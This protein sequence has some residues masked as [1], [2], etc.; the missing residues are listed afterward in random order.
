MKTLIFE[1]NMKILFSSPVSGHR[2]TVKCIP[3]S[4]DRQQIQKLG[5]NIFPDSS[6]ETGFSKGTDSFGNYC[7]YGECDSLHEYFEIHVQGEAKTGICACEN[8]EPEHMLGRY[9]YSTLYTKPG[10]NIKAY[11]KK[12]QEAFD[13]AFK[14]SGAVL[15]ELDKSLVMMHM[16]YDNFSYVPKVT[17]INTTAEEALTLGK[18]VCQ[19]YAHILVAFCHLEKIPARYVVGMLLGEGASHAWVEIYSQGRWYALDPTN[20]IL[21]DSDHIKISH[22]RDYKDCLINQGVFTGTAKQ[23]QEIHVLV[24]EKTESMEAKIDD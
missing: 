18:G 4:N 22:G 20:N 5:Y 2:F 3:Q 19:D 7:V 1:Y 21:V 15:S 12:C 9:R 23:T 14:E 17:N 11:H 13:C 10:E 6:L 8:A 24:T 16:L